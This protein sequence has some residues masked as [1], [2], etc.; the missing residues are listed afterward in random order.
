MHELPLIEEILSVSLDCAGRHGA[1]EIKRINLLAGNLSGIIPKWASL[2]F[3]MIARD[4]IAAEAELVFQTGTAAVLCRRCSQSS[5]ISVNPPVFACAHCGSKDVYLE[6]G[7]EF[8]I[9]S[10][11]FT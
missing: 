10:I 6:T 11:E 3:R 4:T 1:R 7:R 9:Q 5:E 2:F 8:Q